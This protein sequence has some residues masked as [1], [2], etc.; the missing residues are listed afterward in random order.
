ML[1][2]QGLEFY[3]VMS[4]SQTFFPI[5]FGKNYSLERKSVLLMEWVR[6]KI[7][8]LG[9][10]GVKPNMQST[11]SEKIIISNIAAYGHVICTMPYYWILK[12]FGAIWLSNLII[13]LT[14]F[15]LS[16]PQLNRLG[17][18][19]A[20]RILLVS[21]INIDVYLYTAS[22]GMASEIQN[23]FFFTLV[24]PLMLFHFS[25]WRSIL[26]CIIQPFVLWGMLVWQG[27]WIIPQTHFDPLAIKLFGPAIS[28]TTATMLFSC[29]ILV[30]FLHY[31]S[32]SRLQKAKEAAEASDRA[33]SR[34]LATMSHEIRT[35]MNG[36]FGVLQNLRLTELT[37]GQ[38]DEIELLQSSGELLLVIINDVLDFS[39]IDAGKLNLETRR[40]HLPDTT[41]SVKKMLD[42]Q[43]AGKGL[44][45][46][47][48]IADDCPIWVMGDEVR[49]RQVVMNLTNNA[50]KF[51]KAGGVR[52]FLQ[53]GE[54]TEN[55]PRI[56]VKVVDSGIG[57]TEEAL[58]SLF[59]PFQQG[60]SS[61]TREYG[62]TGLGLAICKGIATAMNGNLTVESVLGSGSSFRF[63]AL[64]QRA[65]VPESNEVEQKSIPTR[66]IYAGYKVLIV[67][68][69]YINQIVV[70]KICQ[71]LGFGVTTALNGEEAVE[72][73]KNSHFDLI[74]MDC[75]MPIMDGY[76][77]TKAI[78]AWENSDSRVPIIALTANSLPEDKL[79]C[80]DSG[81]DDFISKP[82]L[83]S[84][85]MEVLKKHIPEKT[86]V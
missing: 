62:G 26:F 86:S 15:F 19:R 3:L 25:E 59:Q 36:V 28:F 9:Y 4:I 31:R 43:A 21:I 14:L 83:I 61:T 41:R 2:Y 44:A 48:V 11:Q 63:D 6:N 10:S 50:L 85:L 37:Q 24:A 55:E 46:E 35:P 45:L 16:V 22:V 80:K 76:D 47:L 73:N 29:A 60:D 77:A 72:A 17:F 49:F 58:K 34:F 81:M 64:F 53:L 70:S 40:F 23:V 54:G 12:Y 57:M 1:T 42:S 32:E 84:V 66:P 38:K 51:T 18:T 74:L 20:S 69:N 7:V 30:T 33:K 65:Q 68:D 5:L 71:K 39:K 8:P 56:I 13:P 67:E 52:I 79:K 75:Q 78:R 27:P 82:L